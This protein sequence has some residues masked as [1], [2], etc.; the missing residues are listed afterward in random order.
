MN[1]PRATTR[2]PTELSFHSLRHTAATLL[3][4]AGVARAVV[5]AITGHSSD[6]MSE[7]YTHVGIEALAKATAALPAL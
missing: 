7:L 5:Q 6:R 2:K 4:Q 1:Q 3:E